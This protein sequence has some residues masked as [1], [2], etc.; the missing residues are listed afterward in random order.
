MAAEKAEQAEALGRHIVRSNVV[1]A[2]AA[3]PGRRAPIIITREMVEGMVPGSVIVDLAAVSGGNCE[4]TQPGK[5]VRHQ[6]VSVLGP[7]NPAAA[8]AGH[9]SELY[10]QN[11]YSFVAPWFAAAG[12]R[13]IPADDEV[14]S[15]SLVAGDLPRAPESSTA[16]DVDQE[17]S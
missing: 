10:A 9:A 16:T 1:I 17:A 12:T 11:C 3:V 15:T 8:L 5:T 6:G 4:L 14:Y 7:T 13:A 2:T